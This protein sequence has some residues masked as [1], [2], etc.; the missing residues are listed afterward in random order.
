MAE[1][2]VALSRGPLD[3]V[4]HRG[5]IAVVDADGTLV[6]AVGDPVAKMA[7]WRSA[8]KPFQAMPLLYS[9]AAERWSLTP[10]DLAVVC[11]SHNGEPQHMQR[12]AALLER[13]GFGT[14]DLV[15]GPHPPLDPST[16]E[17]LLRGGGRP[18]ALHSNCSGNHAGM[19][20]LARRL[21]A[22]PRG[23][24]SPIHRVQKEILGNI[25]CFTGLESGD[26]AVGGDGCG[27][28][29]FG[30]SVYHMALAFARLTAPSGLVDGK[31]VLAA[32]AICRSMMAHPYMVAGRERFDTEL[33]LAA[34]GRLVAKGGAGGVCCI[35]LTSGIGIAL[36]L[37]DGADPTA[38]GRPTTVAA[39]ETLRQLGALEDAALAGLRRFAH[40]VV[41]DIS[42]H[43]VGEARPSF[44]LTSGSSSSRS[45]PR[46][47]RP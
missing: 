32:E 31:R 13:A 11:G 27:V 14:E 33:M 25:C 15:C 30:T 47:A 41:G 26:I 7:Y 20:I 45:R 28:P 29:T 16:A 46:A 40:P 1:P 43:P 23:Y 42:G 4:I 17:A 6:A 19:L 3:D 35:G 38:A 39:V 37:E 34:S 10:A 36:K 5:D 24:E 9:G 21:G 22:D 8:A 18:T 44:T 2:V 12:V